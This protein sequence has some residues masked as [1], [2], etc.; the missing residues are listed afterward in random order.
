MLGKHRL[1]MS[2]VLLLPLLAY[3]QPPRGEPGSDRGFGGG[4]YGGGFGGGGFGGQREANRN[5]FPMWSNPA[6]FETDTFTFARIRYTS[7]NAG[8]WG[9]RW[10]NDFPDSDWNF[11]YRLSEMTTMHVDPNGRVLE[12]TDAELFDY[13]FVFMNGVGTAEFSDEEALALR[14]IC[15]AVAL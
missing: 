6:G 2:L 11:S 12:L 7:R 9:N 15:C 10:S 3:A 5:D 13:P 4:G 1:L 8:G 14:N